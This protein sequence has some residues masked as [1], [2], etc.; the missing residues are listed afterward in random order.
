[1]LAAIGL[2]A[3]AAARVGAAGGGAVAAARFFRAHVTQIAPGAGMPSPQP[4]VHGQV[5]AAS[6]VIAPGV[7]AEIDELRFSSI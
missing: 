7:W 4:P 5:F 1:V 6:F 3:A 2:L